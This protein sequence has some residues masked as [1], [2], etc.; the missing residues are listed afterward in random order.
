[1]PP[2]FERQ[3]GKNCCIHA[4]NN[5]RGRKEL[6][7]EKIKKYARHVADGHRKKESRELIYNVFIG[8]GGIS[9]SIIKQYVKDCTSLFMF[10]VPKFRTLKQL[11]S[12]WKSHTPL[13]LYISTKVGGKKGYGHQISITS[14]DGKKFILWDSQLKKPFKIDTV[15]KFKALMKRYEIMFVDVVS[16]HKDKRPKNTEVTEVI[17][18]D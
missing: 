15:E 17:E 3:V 5:A 12:T 11:Q 7:F 18:I 10:G 2:F 6:T 4:W 8:S 13:F 16:E 9:P 14:V 1:M